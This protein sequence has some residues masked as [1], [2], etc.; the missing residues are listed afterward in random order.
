MVRGLYTGASGMLSQWHNMNVV[1]NNLANINTTAFKKD[2]ALFKSFPEML[3]R[4]LDDNGV[5]KIPPGSY[6]IA[7]IVGKI[8]TGTELNE[9]YTR[10]EQGSLRSTENDFD[11][12]LFGKGFFVVNT[13]KGER[14]TR[15]G[16]FTMDKDGFLVTKEGFR[17]Q[18]EKGDIRVKANNFRI[19]EYGEIAMNK[20]YESKDLGQFVDKIGNEWKKSEIVDKLRIVNFYDELGLRKEGNSYYQA[21][22][23]SGEAEDKRIGEGRA[24]VVQGFIEVSNVNPVL[25]MTRMIE[26]QRSYEASQKVVT[27]NDHLLSK[28]V[29]DLPRA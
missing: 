27:S 28:A 10:H 16:N 8:G 3:I 24:K 11:M 22:K 19:G 5:V 25:E 7:P 6:D 17:I 21:T 9:I 20:E 1:A 4:R 14:Y 23:Y 15:N 26:V 12:A 29:S 13:G 2:E 18:G